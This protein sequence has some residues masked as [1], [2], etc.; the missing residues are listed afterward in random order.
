[1]NGTLLI[2]EDQENDVLFFRHAFQKAGILNPVQ[3]V[4]DGQQALDYIRGEGKYADRQ[5]Y[6]LPSMVFLDLKLPQVHGLDV[7]RWIREQQTLPPIVV[8]VWTSSSLDE[9][10]AR[11]YR[12][13]A[14]AYVVKP[15]SMEK[16]IEIVKD[17]ANWW[18]KHNELPPREQGG[19]PRIPIGFSEKSG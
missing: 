3:V 10:I 7:L 8:V 9:D 13:G 5:T 4:E 11:A 6:P 18:F 14:N 16:L 1:M 17:F 2:V 12:L 15:S 19:S